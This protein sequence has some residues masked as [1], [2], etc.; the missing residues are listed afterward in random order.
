MDLDTDDERLQRAPRLLADGQWRQLRVDKAL[1]EVVRRLA[2]PAY[3]DR[4]AP[5]SGQ[6]PRRAGRPLPDHRRHEPSSPTPEVAWRPLDP[7]R[8]ALLLDLDRELPRADLVGDDEVKR[9]L[10]GGDQEQDCGPGGC[11]SYDGRAI[12]AVKA[13]AAISTRVRH[14][15]RALLLFACPNMT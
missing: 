9:F 15:G 14:L 1:E 4:F 10:D 12:S 8:D 6:L 11:V 5:V 7:R 3:A 2:S 13:E